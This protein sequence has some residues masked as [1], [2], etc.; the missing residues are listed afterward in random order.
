MSLRQ[1]RFKLFVRLPRL[2]LDVRKHR[3]RL[4]SGEAVPVSQHVTSLAHE[5]LSLADEDSES[6]LLHRVTVTKTTDPDTQAI[7]PYSFEFH[8]LLEMETLTR[9]WEARLLVIKVCLD[10]PTDKEISSAQASSRFDIPEARNERERILANEIMAWQCARRLD[11]LRR[12]LMQGLLFLWDI[13]LDLETF[14][15]RP[16]S[17]SQDWILRQASGVLETDVDATMMGDGGGFL[18][19]SHEG[20]QRSSYVING[21]ASALVWEAD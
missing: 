7:M 8:N 3:Q 21:P 19:N 18:A 9:Y 13:A 1:T 17:V 15:G 11:L 2:V 5:L 12:D 14:R 4:Q 20:I 6:R 10:L 16:A